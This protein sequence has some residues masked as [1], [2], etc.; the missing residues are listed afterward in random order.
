LLEVA[1]KLKMTKPDWTFHLVGKDF[2][3]NYSA[4][5]K[6][7]IQR[8]K[9]V[10]KLLIGLFQNQIKFQLKQKSLFVE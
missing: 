5:I 2:E 8:K 1:E 9:L 10:F 6:G 7:L 3:D 4:K